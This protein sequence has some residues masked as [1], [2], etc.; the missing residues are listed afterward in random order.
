M[1]RIRLVLASAS[2]RRAEL[3]RSVGIEP[4]VRPSGIDERALD[5]ETPT[6]TVARLA[7]AKAERV[8]AELGRDPAAV[9]LAAD[10]AVVLDGVALGKPTDDDDA[11]A[12]L[13]RLAGRTHEVRTGVCVVAGAAEA[14]V[15][16]TSVVAFRP[17]PPGWIR[18]YVSTGEPR[19]KAGAYGIQGRGAWLAESVAGSWTNVVGLPVERLPDLL[20]RV[21]VDPLALVSR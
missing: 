8:A 13:A 11:V 10:T 18:W 1:C 20:A 19:D 12:M 14:S 15:V 9:V 7:R 6:D 4:D 21:G 17:L 3:L 2:P 16:E 5:G